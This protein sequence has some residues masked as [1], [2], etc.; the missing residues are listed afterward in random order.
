MP[1]IFYFYD[2]WAIISLVRGGGGGGHAAH[3]PNVRS[4]RAIYIEWSLKFA[5]Y[6]DER[7]GLC[8][9]IW[10]FVI[11]ITFKFFFIYKY[12]ACV[13]IISTLALWILAVCVC[14]K[15]VYN[16]SEEHQRFFLRFTR[17][18]VARQLNWNCFFCAARKIVILE[19]WNAPAQLRISIFKSNFF[20]SHPHTHCAE[21]NRRQTI[22]H[23]YDRAK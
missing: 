11:F 22:A 23:L 18:C 21:V 10:P 8:Y 19:R 1:F 3:W 16:I 5:N 6:N 20:L 12:N 9:C 17:A 2:H 14:V 4:A 7:A 15:N 13:K